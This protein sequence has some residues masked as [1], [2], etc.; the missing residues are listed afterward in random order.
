MGD[1][2]TYQLSGG[3]DAV[4]LISLIILLMMWTFWTFGIFSSERSV[5]AQLTNLLFDINDN[6]VA[7]GAGGTDELRLGQGRGHH[8]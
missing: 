3:L 7:D 1:S 5:T 2:F 8:V 4:Q 6:Y